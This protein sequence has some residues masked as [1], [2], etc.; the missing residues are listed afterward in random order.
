M[1]QGGLKIKS[2]ETE[3]ISGIF[4]EYSSKINKRSSDEVVHVCPLRSGDKKLAFFSG[5]SLFVKSF[6][7][8]RTS[9]VFF[10]KIVGFPYEILGIA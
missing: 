2:I 9:Y 3:I 7:L 5:R 1:K 6:G 10:N 8:L 4:H